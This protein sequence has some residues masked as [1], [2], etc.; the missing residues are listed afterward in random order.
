MANHHSPA[1]LLSLLTPVCT[2]YRVFTHQSLDLENWS[3]SARFLAADSRIQRLGNRSNLVDLQ[4]QAVAGFFLHGLANAGGVGHREVVSNHL[5]VCAF[6]EVGPGRPVILVKGIFDGNHCVCALG[7]RLI[8]AMH[9]WIIKRHSEYQTELKC[10]Q[11]S[12]DFFFF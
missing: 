5:D 12:L 9:H 10:Q 2:D 6:S 11:L 1:V 4:Q 8:V 7:G 3:T